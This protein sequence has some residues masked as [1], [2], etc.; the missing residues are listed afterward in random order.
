MQSLRLVAESAAWS[1]CYAAHCGGI[2]GSSDRYNVQIGKENQF[3]AFTLHRR[4]G[5]TTRIIEHL[6][7]VKSSFGAIPFDLCTDAGYG[8]EENY[9]CLES[10]GVRA[11]VKY[12]IF[13][14]EQK[15]SFKKNPTQPKNWVF[16]GEADERACVEGRTLSSN[17]RRKR[18]AI[19]AMR[20]RRGCIVVRI[21]AATFTRRSAPKATMLLGNAPFR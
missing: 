8:S 18:E 5:D 3:V 16:D 7:H 20:A 10:Q 2:E 13:G 17:P 15:R 1:M 4:P 6:E 9:A 14:T 19:W 21:A 11:F 12:S